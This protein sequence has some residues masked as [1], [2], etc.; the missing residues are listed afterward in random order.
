MTFILYPRHRTY[1]ERPPRPYSL[2]VRL[3]LALRGLAPAGPGPLEGGYHRIRFL[4]CGHEAT[5]SMRHIK[6]D[7]LAC[8]TCRRLTR[9]G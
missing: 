3:A 4:G 2:S 9:F 1:H 7:R 8:P 6:S 5:Y